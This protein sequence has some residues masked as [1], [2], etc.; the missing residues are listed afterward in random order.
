MQRRAV[1]EKLLSPAPLP[2]L[3]KPR[4]LS[5]REYRNQ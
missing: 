1:E 4:L 3:P 5:A 2:P